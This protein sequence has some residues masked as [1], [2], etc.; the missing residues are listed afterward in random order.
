MFKINGKTNAT[1]GIGFLKIII[2]KIAGRE[3]NI[4]FK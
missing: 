2:L 3:K 1:T 4:E